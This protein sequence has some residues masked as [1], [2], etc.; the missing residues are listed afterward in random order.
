MHQRVNFG[1]FIVNQSFGTSKIIDRVFDGVLLDVK[2]RFA[3]GVGHRLW[4]RVEE[5]SGEEIVLKASHAW[6]LPIQ[7]KLKEDLQSRERLP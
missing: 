4:S 5:I 6:K 2:N 3:G 7:C 1:K